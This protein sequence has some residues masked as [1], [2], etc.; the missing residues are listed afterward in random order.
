MLLG[1][2]RRSLPCWHISS[3]EGTGPSEGRGTRRSQRGR[4][5]RERR[6]RIRRRHG[7]CF[8]AGGGLAR[9]VTFSIVDWLCSGRRDVGARFGVTIDI[10]N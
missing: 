2:H 8:G 1:P 10:D 6:R 9:V 5:S 4:Q 3:L 7:G